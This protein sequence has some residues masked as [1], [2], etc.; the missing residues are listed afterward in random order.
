MATQSSDQRLSRDEQC[1]K[2]TNKIGEYIREYT[3]LGRLHSAVLLAISPVIGA[4]VMGSFELLFLIVLFIIG[5]LAHV[6]GFVMNEYADIEVDMQSDDLSEK[7]LVK[8]TISPRSALGVSIGAMATMYI[9][10]ILIAICSSANLWILL[11]L[12]TL[13]FGFALAYDLFGKRL[14]GSDAVLSFWPSIL[15][16]FGAFAVM[17]TASATAT[18]TATALGM[19]PLRALNSLPPLLYVVAILAYLQ[20]LLQNALAGLKDVDHDHLA[21]AK[22]TPTR[23]G[24]KVIDDVNVTDGVKVTDRRLKMTPSFII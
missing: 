16:F 18:A 8:G 2:K 12:I 14:M 22:T 3:K 11:V 24:V 4:L 10:T 7:P 13:Y 9:L 23:L 21:N 15:V 5:F 20:T 1:L 6:F 17:P 19:A